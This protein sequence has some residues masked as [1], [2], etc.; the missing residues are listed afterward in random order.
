MTVPT[1]AVTY[2]AA[3]LCLDARE[4]AGAAIAVHSITSPSGRL[5]ELVN[6]CTEATERGL[7]R[8]HLE[9]VSQGHRVTALLTTEGRAAKRPWN[10]Y[11]WPAKGDFIKSADPI[12]NTPISALDLAQWNL[13]AMCP[14]AQLNPVP[15]PAGPTCPFLEPPLIDPD[16]ANLPDLAPY[17]DSHPDNLPGYIFPGLDGQIDSLRAGDDTLVKQA[18]LF[19]AV[20]L[21][22]PGPLIL[23]D[24]VFGTAALANELSILAVE[25]N[26]LR[27]CGCWNNHYLPW[28]NPWTGHCLEGAWASVALDQPVPTRGDLSTDALEGLWTEA[29]TH[30]L[31]TDACYPIRILRD[32]P[33]EVPRPGADASDSYARRLHNA[34]HEW[35]SPD[36]IDRRKA[37][38][39]DLR[40]DTADG[41]V[42]VWNHAIYYFHADWSQPTSALRSLVRLELFANADD[43]F[44][45]PNGKIGQVD[46]EYGTC[47]RDPC[48]LP[49]VGRGDALG[50][51]SCDPLCSGVR[52]HDRRATW[53]Y[54]LEYVPPNSRDRLPDQ[55]PRDDFIAITGD[56]V[57]LPEGLHRDPKISA[58][59]SEGDNT[60]VRV[61]KVRTLDAAN[62]TVSPNCYP[63]ISS[64]HI[65]RVP[66]R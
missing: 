66:R 65:R 47:L 11:W 22:K 31:P 25:S 18:N 46:G 38:I 43:Q 6:G 15:P 5:L 16:P 56:A 3:R 12:A 2:S 17:L 59:K 60:E 21:G 58:Y 37:L 9:N 48:Y 26:P 54:Q 35:M 28:A 52:W 29:L 64:E 8:F 44:P 7:Y 40:S 51:P 50:D 27:A 39:A 42:S 41:G 33:P 13:D 20:V 32:I 61:D 53:T 62:S 19:D 4:G 34:L 23:Y 49:G 1:E 24:S 63:R 55:P 14:T 45:T 57:Y 10:F 30:T 36:R